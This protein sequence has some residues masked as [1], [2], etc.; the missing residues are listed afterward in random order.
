MAEAGRSPGVE[1]GQRHR[2]PR[3]QP[4]VAGR[5]G[6][7]AARAPASS[8][9]RTGSFAA[10]SGSTAPRP[11]ASTPRASSSRRASSISTPTS[12]SP[13]FED[14]E[15]VATGLGGRRPWRVHDGLRHAEHGAA[16]RR[17]ERARP[18]ARCGRPVRVAGR[19]RCR[20]APSASGRAGETLAALGELAD[21]GAIG[22]SDDGVAGPIAGDPAQRAGLRRQ[23]SGARCRPSPR[24]RR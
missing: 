11:T 19:G 17:G 24:S 16:D 5:P 22:F 6:G 14:A 23:R 2:R 1:I 9:S 21:G 3:D 13:G 10:S 20:T 8:S 4:R 18:R 15:T 7:R 12:G